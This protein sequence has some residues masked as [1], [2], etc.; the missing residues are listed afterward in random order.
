MKGYVLVAVTIIT[1]YTLPT[2]MQF[3]ALQFPVLGFL[4]DS[5]FY[6]QMV[7][8]YH[9]SYPES[10]PIP[11]QEVD[12]NE[13]TKERF[14]KLTNNVRYPL[15]IRNAISKE[16]I[17]HLGKRETWSSNYS[18]ETDWMICSDNSYKKFFA[19]SPKDIVNDY[20]EHDVGPNTLRG[21]GSH[22]LLYANPDILELLETNISTWIPRSNSKMTHNPV[23]EIFFSVQGTNTPLHGALRTNIVKQVAGKKRWTLVDPSYAYMTGLVNNEATFGA[24]IR[25]IQK[26][27]LYYDSEWMKRVPRQE[28]VLS[29]GDFLLM[30]PFWAHTIENMETIPAA[31]LTIGIPE[32]YVYIP[33]G[34]SN[35][36]FLSINMIIR[37]LVNRCGIKI[38]DALRGQRTP[39]RTDHLP[40][41]EGRNAELFDRFMIDNRILETTINNRVGKELPDYK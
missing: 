21:Q 11:I 8:F 10:D 36:P 39:L 40:L 7:S 34:L 3:F 6:F 25:P 32:T 38:Q 31:E 22:Y 23:H 4:V 13:L 16:S 35:N 12:G 17:D 19:C 5:D 18:K 28:T 20:N 2:M 27:V 1:L 29:P 30:P 33:T 14:L 24:T 37:G 15:V 41:H 26:M 9:D